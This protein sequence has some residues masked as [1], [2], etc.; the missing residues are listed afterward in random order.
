MVFQLISEVDFGN[1]AAADGV[2]QERW[3]FDVYAATIDAAL[4]IKEALYTALHYKYSV[5]WSGYKIYL[6]MR[7]AGGDV[8]GEEPNADGS[9]AA[10]KRITQ[11][12]SIK[13][14]HAA[15]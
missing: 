12:Y 7:A 8:F 5:T 10:Y 1:I 13:R 9:E 15:T 11:D 6:A 4:T 14:N 2:V 3:Q